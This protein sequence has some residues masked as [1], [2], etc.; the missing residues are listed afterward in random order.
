MKYVRYTVCDCAKAELGQKWLEAAPTLK[1]E[2]L[3]R[4]IT[5][6]NV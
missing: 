1:H 5:V 2:P 3:N 6:Q 4:C